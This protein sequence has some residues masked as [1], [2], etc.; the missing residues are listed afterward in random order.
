[1]LA[2][3]RKNK[4]DLLALAIIMAIAIPFFIHLEK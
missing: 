3:E 4:M 1:M 2:T